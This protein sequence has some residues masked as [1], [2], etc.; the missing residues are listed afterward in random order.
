LDY[1]IERLDMK[2]GV[3]SD[4]HIHGSIKTLPKGISEHFTGVDMIIHAGDITHPKVLNL[5]HKIAPVKAVKGNRGNEEKKLSR[6]L[7]SQ[8][9]LKVDSYN[10]GVVH[11]LSNDFERALNYLLYKKLHLFEIANKVLFKRLKARFSESVDC[12]VFG[13]SHVPL[14]RTVNGILFFNPGAAYST[15]KRRASIGILEVSKQRLKTKII[16]L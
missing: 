11:G 12:I 7:P 4:T 1:T 10:I 13:D 16:Y 2:I 15:K 14:I 6:T 3:I 9:I 5:L 8:L